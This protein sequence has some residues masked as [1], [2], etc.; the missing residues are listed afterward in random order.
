MQ[1][2]LNP[3]AAEQIEATE[4]GPRNLGQLGSTRV[5]Y[6]VSVLEFAFAGTWTSLPELIN[7]KRKNIESDG[8]DRIGLLSTVTAGYYF[9]DVY[10]KVCLYA[11]RIHSKN[12]TP[13]LFKV[14]DGDAIAAAKAARMQ[15]E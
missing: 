3:L 6:L 9:R 1:A 11:L 15:R 14:A 8:L 12:K 13:V 7:F 4:P 2:L 5:E 10:S